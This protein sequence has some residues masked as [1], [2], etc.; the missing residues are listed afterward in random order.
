MFDIQTLRYHPV[1]MRWLYEQTKYKDLV[2]RVI[3]IEQ[4]NPGQTQSTASF[5]NIDHKIEDSFEELE[6]HYKRWRFGKKHIVDL[7]NQHNHISL[8]KPEDERFEVESDICRDEIYFHFG[9]EVNGF[10]GFYAFWEEDT[11]SLAYALVGGGD[12]SDPDLSPEELAA[13]FGPIFYGYLRA[14][15]N[16]V[17]DTIMESLGASD[18]ISRQKYDSLTGAIKYMMSV[19]RHVH[20][21]KGGMYSCWPGDAPGKYV[22]ANLIAKRQKIKPNKGLEYRNAK[23]MK[24]I[25]YN[26]LWSR[27]WPEIL[28]IPKP[29]EEAPFLDV[30]KLH[31]LH[32]R[33]DEMWRCAHQIIESERRMALEG[34]K[35]YQISKLYEAMREIFRSGY[36][37]ASRETPESIFHNKYGK[38]VEKALNEIGIAIYGDFSRND[39]N[40]AYYVKNEDT[41]WGLYIEG[42]ASPLK[43]SSDRT[44]NE[45]AE[46]GFLF[47][48]NGKAWATEKVEEHFAQNNLRYKR[49]NYTNFLWSEN[50]EQ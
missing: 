31:K 2:N 23:E 17:K 39:K 34:Q 11:K 40:D 32:E 7:T 27:G 44:I 38:D 5:L 24:E 43:I 4:S 28:I 25:T 16:V 41:T 48:D 21:M 45:M 19:L 46:L 22:S 10:D 3:C 13:S 36:R 30:N 18:R 50:S 12:C 8:L 26:H 15:E 42:Y 47:I 20:I 33:D 14:G 6:N 1:R 35:S 49:N 9:R 37:T 29:Q